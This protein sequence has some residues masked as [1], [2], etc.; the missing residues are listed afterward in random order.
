VRSARVVSVSAALAPAFVFV[1]LFLYLAVMP[2]AVGAAEAPVTAARLEVQAL[3]DCTSR[4]ELVARVAARSRRIRFDDEAAGPLLRAVIA[5]APRGGAVGE[6][7]ITEPGGKS[8]SRRISA[9]SCAEA[10]D[11]IALII[12]LTLD[13][14]SAARASGPTAPSAPAVGSTP[15]AGSTNAAPPAPPSA[16]RPVP[17]SAATPKTAPPERPPAPESPASPAGGPSALPVSGPAPPVVA[18]WRFGTGAGAQAIAGATPDILPGVAVYLLAALDRNALWSPAAV[19]WGTHAATSGLVEPGGTAA[20]TLD[21]VTLDA[22][23]LR[24]Q[25]SAFEARACASALYGRLATSGSDTF[26]AAT[27]TRPYAVAGGAVLLSARIARLFEISGRV[28]GG[29]SLI[30]DSFSFL[31]ASPPVFH[32]TAAATVSAGL[33][34]GLR[35]P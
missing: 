3:P 7:L 9:P 11:A 12:A 14:T 15:V 31:S 20:F 30:R 13:P 19:V 5:P 35:F 8:S 6:L 26:S 33:E 16:E 10:T 21:A 32:R 1:F 24:I 34:I 25:V 4:E 23:A 2:V 28:G 18:E 22:C 27:V 29:A 17:P